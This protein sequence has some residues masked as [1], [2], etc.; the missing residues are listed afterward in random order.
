MDKHVVI[1]GNLF[2]IDQPN[3]VKIQNKSHHPY[4]ITMKSVKTLITIKSVKS[5][6]RHSNHVIFPFWCEYQLFYITSLENPEG[7]ERIM[8]EKCQ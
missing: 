3:L 5:V 1:Y 6:K 7:K 8:K 2:G 4:L